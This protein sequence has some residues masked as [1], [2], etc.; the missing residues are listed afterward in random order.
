MPTWNPAQYLQFG[1]ERL[2]PALDLL[3]RIPLE[4]PATVY[5]LGCGPGTAT[6]L[7]KER[8]PDAGVT[9]LD[10][11][12]SMLERARTL[13][14]GITW[15][16]VDLGTWEPDAPADVLFS[17]AV[18]HWL[19]DHEILFPRL[20][21]ALNPGGVLAI[22]M[23]NNFAAPSHTSIT[24]T[25]RGGPWRELFEPGLREFPVGDASTYY[26]LLSPH[27]SHLNIWETTYLHILSGENP[28]VEWTKGTALRPFLDQLDGDQAVAFLDTYSSLID[29]AYPQRK[30]GNTTLPFKRVFI[31]AVK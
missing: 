21:S 12:A 1:N 17:N 9:G 25:I 27:A 11:S 6:V 4:T 14:D 23:P 20:L 24:A 19:D 3:A 31:I 13:D 5:D 18:F 16:E 2:R 29:A 7:L 22:Q 10:S 15:Q 28:V 8:W 30:D 26:D